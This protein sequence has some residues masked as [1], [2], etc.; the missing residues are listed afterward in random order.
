MQGQMTRYS[1]RWRIWAAALVVAASSTWATAAA[2]MAGPLTI[3]VRVTD[4][5]RAPI[6]GADLVV[7][8]D[9]REGVV[10]GR[11]DASGRFVFGFAADEQVSYTVVARKIGYLPATLPLATASGD[12][13]FLDIVLTTGGPTLDTVRINQRSLALAK[14]PFLGADEI[15]KDTRSIL[16]LGD[17][18]AK[19]RPDIAYQSHKCVAGE[20]LRPLIHGPLPPLHGPI[21]PPYQAKVYVNGRYIPGDADPWRSIRAEHIAE[22]RYVNCLDNSIPGLPEQA[23]PT[24]YVALKPGY[25]WDVKKGTYQLP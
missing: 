25:G 9:G 13:V 20:R 5:A 12:S 8:K 1:M 15:E 14:Q 17:A 7:V 4:A 23:W 21:K 3:H 10:F 11:T 18:L 6:G 19:L 22:I 24:V 2:Q 16:S